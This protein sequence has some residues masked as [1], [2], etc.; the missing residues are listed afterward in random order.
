MASEDYIARAQALAPLIREHADYA[1]RERRLAAPVAEAFAREGLYRVAAP[2]ACHGAEADP[3]T[4]IA[5]IEAVSRADG[6]AGWNLMIG[7]ETFGLIGPGFLETCPEL[8]ED[9]MVVMASST[10]AVGKA[11]RVDGAWRVNGQWQFVSGIH[12]AQLFGATVQLFDDGELIS[13]GPK[14]AVV[15]LGEYEILDTWHVGG[16]RGSGSHDVR[17]DNVVVPNERIIAPIGGNT[18]ESPQL[19]FP[20]SSRLAYN[21]VAVGLGIAR[22]A[23]DAFVDLA[24]RK[25]PRFTTRTLRDRPFAQRALAKAEARIHGARAATFEL[26]EQMWEKVCAFD[27]V[28][29]EERALFQIICSDAAQASAEVVDMLAEAAG[30]SANQLGHP[31]ERLGRDARVIRQHVT[32]A[33]HHIEDGGRVLLGLEPESNMLATVKS[34]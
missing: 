16:L 11:E 6:S 23:I 22:A 29:I 13:Q 34:R 1:E 26:V 10:A 4:Q 14:Y 7:I 18:S 24:T 8:I 17:L 2:E 9:P 25:K 12:N 27:E 20:L 32:V 19:R 33:P 28:T 21:K 5:V 30:T 15:P 31:L 3:M